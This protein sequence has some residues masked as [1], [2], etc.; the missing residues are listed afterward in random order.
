M[1]NPTSP[2]CRTLLAAYY[3]WLISD[4]SFL[5][6]EKPVDH[7]ATV[8][9]GA[10][11]GMPYNAIRNAL[12]RDG[13]SVLKSKIDYPTLLSWLQVRRGFVPLREEEQPNSRFTWRVIHALTSTTCGEGFANVRAILGAIPQELDEAEERLASDLATG[14]CPSESDLRDYAESVDALVDTF[15]I[16]MTE[17]WAN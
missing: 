16:A 10:L 15:I 11:S 4:G 8:A 6:G 13:I 2:L 1:D 12:S 5:T 17:H 9:I 3:R 14:R 7:A